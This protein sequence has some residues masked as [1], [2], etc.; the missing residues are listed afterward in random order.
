MKRY[1]LKTEQYIRN[2]KHTR[3]GRPDLTRWG[4]QFTALPRFGFM[5]HRSKEEKRKERKGMEREKEKGK[6]GD[7]SLRHLLNPTFVTAVT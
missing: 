7:S 3:P 2:V 5:G 1:G 6:G 4:I